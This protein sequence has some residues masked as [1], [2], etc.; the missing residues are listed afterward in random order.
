MIHASSTVD[1]FGTLTYNMQSS[2]KRPVMEGP[3]MSLYDPLAL[4]LS[5]L[6]LLP[7]LRLISYNLRIHNYSHAFVNQNVHN[8]RIAFVNVYY[9]FFFCYLFVFLVNFLKKIWRKF[10]IM[11]NR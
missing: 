5:S 9:T 1:Y 6:I 11:E 8:I 10:P 3:K 2:A 7:R 4:H